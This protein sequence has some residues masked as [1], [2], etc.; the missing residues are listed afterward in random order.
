MKARKDS[1]SRWK[2]NEMTSRISIERTK[3]DK[4]LS[5]NHS[6]HWSQLTPW[7]KHFPKYFSMVH[8]RKTAPWVRKKDYWSP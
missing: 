7:V 5:R 6:L 8:G 4:N 2:W 1:R 3:C